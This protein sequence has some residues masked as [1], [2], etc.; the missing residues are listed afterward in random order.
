M[1]LQRL[2]DTFAA[3]R[4]INI[5]RRQPGEKILTADQVAAPESHRADCPVPLHGNESH[6]KISTDKA[7]VHH[8]GKERPAGGFT[9]CALLP[10]NDLIGKLGGIAERYNLDHISFP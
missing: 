9:K 5:E 7:A 2:T 3:H 10:V 6:R 1:L 4:L 8:T